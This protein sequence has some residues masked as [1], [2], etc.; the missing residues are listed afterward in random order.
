MRVASIPRGS[1]LKALHATIGVR[2]AGLDRP[3]V[4]A[5]LL[6]GRRELSRPEL[7]AVVGGDLLELPAGR[8]ELARDEVDELLGPAGAGVAI[9]LP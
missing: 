2:V 7:G 5:G 9:A 6:A 3:P 8:F 1:E 4:G